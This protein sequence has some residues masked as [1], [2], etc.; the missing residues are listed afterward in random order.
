M[1]AS[2]G[3]TWIDIEGLRDAETFRKLSAILDIHQLA[4]EDVAY[5]QRPKVQLYND[6]LVLVLYVVQGPE[7]K[8][9]QVTFLLKGQLLLTFQEGLVTDIFEPIRHRLSENG[10]QLRQRAADYLL[11]ALVDAVIDS[12]FPHIDRLAERLELLEEECL[13]HPT[14]QTL[15]SLRGLK[16]QLMDL[17]RSLRP[18]QDVMSNLTRFSSSF[19]EESNRVYFHDCFDHCLQ[20]LDQVESYREQSSLLLDSYLSSLSNRMNEVMKSLTLVATIFMPLSFIAGV[21][22][23]NFNSERSLWN[24]PELNW[25]YGYPFALGL[26]ILVAALMLFLVKR[27]GWL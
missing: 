22:G 16:K 20:L 13:T 7:L 9:E 10:G 1:V 18:M 3:V 21:Y 25:T 27:K 17:R 26:M 5:H 6:H 8:L 11:Y 15:A 2:D 19:I 4:L 14:Q 24:M 23:M 12:Y